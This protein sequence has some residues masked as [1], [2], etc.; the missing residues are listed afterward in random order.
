MKWVTR[1]NANVDRI[2]CPWLIK[3]F[4][5]P[6]AAF[7]YV[8]ADQVIAVA[9]REGA[10]PYDVA[11][12]ELGHVDGRCSFES[13]MLKYGLTDDKGLAELAKIVHAADVRDDIDTS[14]Y[15]RG[16]KA[17][18]YGFAY[19]HGKD[20]HKKI[21]LE[22]PMYDALYAFCQQQAAQEAAS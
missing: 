10:I 11:N 1:E 9:E 8:P 3:R 19:L 20:D 17:I 21:A 12:V 6:D 2:A 7:L 13:I 16:L 5:D 18:A 22:S 14:P 15:G 4:V